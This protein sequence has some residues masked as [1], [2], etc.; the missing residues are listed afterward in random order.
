[1]I[2]AVGVINH[3]PRFEFLVWSAT[4][5]SVGYTISRAYPV[6]K[7]AET[8]AGL[9]KRS[10]ALINDTAQDGGG[11]PLR[12]SPLTKLQLALI[13]QAVGRFLPPI[14]YWASGLRYMWGRPAWKSQWSFPAPTRRAG[15]W[16]MT[17]AVRVG[18]VNWLRVVGVVL[19]VGIEFFQSS[20]IKTL[21]DQFHMIGVRERPRLVDGGAFRVVRHPMY[22]GVIAA[23][24]AWALAFWS[25]LPIYALPITVA[26]YLVKIPIE[27]RVMEEDPELGPQYRVYKR[28]VPW[29]LIPYFW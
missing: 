13:G 20:V 27:E 11:G 14:V 8:H 10:P 21:G 5:G 29:R 18:R 17:T 22:S 7:A 28:R 23:H 9:I 24:F 3:V 25:W 6:F 2:C 12:L 15:L 26:S 4:L 16:G 1:M 19:A